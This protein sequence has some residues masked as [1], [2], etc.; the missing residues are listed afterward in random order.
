M[1]AMGRAWVGNP[2]L[3]QLQS[4]H[5]NQLAVGN[6]RTDKVEIMCV[7]VVC[8]NQHTIL[9][10]SIIS[11]FYLV[12]K[13]S[14]SRCQQYCQ[15]SSFNTNYNYKA[16]RVQRWPDWSLNEIQHNYPIF[17]CYEEPMQQV[18]VYGKPENSE[19]DSAQDK[20]LEWKLNQILIVFAEWVE[21]YN[22][23]HGIWYQVLI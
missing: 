16:F 11:L 3:F 6:R 21:W 22:T 15:T 17:I 9:F 1:W 20:I 2:M 12:R 10:Q 4:V 5:L 14:N 8:V 19:R 23:F 7:C 18:H 13:S